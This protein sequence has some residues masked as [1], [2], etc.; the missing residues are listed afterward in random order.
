MRLVIFDVDGTLVDSQAL[1][2]RAMQAAYAGIGATA[3]DR[4]LTLSYVGRSLDLIFPDLSPDLTTAQHRALAQGYRDAYQKMRDTE[5]AAAT[6]PLFY[7]AK[8][9]IEAL[10]A[11]PETLL[12][13]ATGKARRGL[14]AVIAG[15]GLEGRFISLQCADHHPSKPHP[16]MV[17]ACLA[18]AG[19]DAGQAV[20]IGDTTF[21]MDMAR[22]AGVATV[23]V[24]WGFHPPDHLGAD[25]IIDTFAALP[26]AIDTLL[27]EP[28]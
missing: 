12:A 25:V 13:V 19:L 8:A 23:G 27:G 15:H 18:D 14:D 3:P 1:I 21:D 17:L 6:S 4:R 10:H 11:Q 28:A 26:K 22:A 7:G 16:S 20:M 5:G 2:W 24:T 9:V